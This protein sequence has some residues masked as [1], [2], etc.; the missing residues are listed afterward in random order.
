[1]IGLT[2]G[3]RDSVVKA[4]AAAADF[5]QRRRSTSRKDTGNAADAGDVGGIGIGGGNKGG[6]NIN[7]GGDGDSVVG[8][9]RDGDSGKSS[10]TPLTK[11]TKKKVLAKWKKSIFGGGKNKGKGGGGGGGV[12]GGG[13]G[14]KETKRFSELKNAGIDAA[15]VTLHGEYDDEDD[16]ADGNENN[17]DSDKSITQ[18]TD[19]KTRT[20]SKTTAKVKIDQHVAMPLPMPVTEGGRC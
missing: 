3:A 16:D 8:A 14:V 19:T 4:V 20:T 15:Q 18:M 10:T 1:M 5:D 9:R 13:G 6:N 11:T 17:D 12:G 2:P 7:G